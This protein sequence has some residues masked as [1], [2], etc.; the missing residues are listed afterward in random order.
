MGAA[1]VRLDPG[2]PS[3]SIRG[4]MLTSPSGNR[5]HRLAFNLPTP[6]GDDPDDFVFAKAVLLNRAVC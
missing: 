4:F 1:T 5:F 6:F 3:S 2:S